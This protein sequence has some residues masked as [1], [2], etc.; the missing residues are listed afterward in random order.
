MTSFILLSSDPKVQ[1]VY[2]TTFLKEYEIDPIDITRVTKETSVKQ[3][4][5]SLGIADVKNMQKQLF[6]KPIKSKTKAVI[7]QDAQ[8][9]TTEAQNALLKVLEEPPEATIIVLVA[10]SK[11][12]LLPTILSRC[13]MIELQTDN[14]KLTEK[15]RA[16][17]T[18]FIVSLENLSIGE[19]LKK[20]E[21]L[22]KDKEKAIVWTENL[23]L[24]LREQLV[25]EILND[26]ATVRSLPCSPRFGRVEAGRQAG[27]VSVLNSLKSLHTLLKTTNVN[28]RFAIE[29]T[30]LAMIS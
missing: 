8:L 3:N 24:I 29:N 6:L 17:Y 26:T 22:A 12:T 13:Q 20:A 16:G 30:L 21:Q 15:A 4:I 25:S 9:L 28:P 14:K 1:Q 7:I 11:E 2:L 18:E 23:I 10:T 19:R 5:Q 27:Q